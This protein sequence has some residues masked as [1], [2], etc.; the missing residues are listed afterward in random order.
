MGDTFNRGECAAEH[1]RVDEKL[2]SHDKRLDDHDKKLEVLEKSDATNTNEIKNLCV[3]LDKQSKA[4]GGQT[5]AIWGLIVSLLLTLL[6][7]FIWYIQ[8]LGTK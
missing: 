5:K 3:G 2:D 7:F 4:I 1:K 8:N 6:G